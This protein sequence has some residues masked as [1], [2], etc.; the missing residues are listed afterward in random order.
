M[1][2]FGS[3]TD[4]ASNFFLLPNVATVLRLPHSLKFSENWK[5]FPM[6]KTAGVGSLT[7]T[8]SSSCRYVLKLP[9]DVPTFH[10][11]L[12]RDVLN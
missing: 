1:G 6:D 5:Y 11:H 12:L 9:G 8:P 7:L 10:V 2:D 4:R 3:I